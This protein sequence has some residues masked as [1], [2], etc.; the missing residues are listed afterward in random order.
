MAEMT[1]R[2]RMLRTLELQRADHLPCCFMSFTAL[3]KRHNENRYEQA[4]AELSMGL[5]AML[6][7][8]N[9]PRPERVDHPD[10]RGLPVR[11][12]PRV[13]VKEWRED[14]PGGYPVLHKEYTTPG[15]RLTAS[16]RTSADWPHGDHI[17]FID[18]YQV[19][20]AAKFLVTGPQDLDALRY[21][22]IPPCEDDIARFRQE[23]GQAKAFVEEHGVLLAGGWG[24]GMDMANWL[25]G[26]ENLMMWAIEQPDFVAELLEM[27]HAWNKKRMEVILS[28]PV[29]LFIRRAWYEGCD[30]VTPAFYR[31]AILPRLKAEVDLAHARGAKFG[32]IC[33]SGTKPMLDYYLEAGIDVLIG[34]DP[35]QGTH[36][37]LELIKRK[38]GGRICLWGGVSGAVTVE[39]GSEEEVRAAVRHAVRT[40]GPAGFILSPVDNITVDA[41]RTWENIGFFIDEWRKQRM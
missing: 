28:A 9:S 21:M 1:S 4:K 13:A 6:F 29:D 19:P 3:R 7:I 27:I 2:E 12:D 32:Y 17:P 39:M 8:P 26:M 34:I 24:V 35:I 25:C 5:D 40:L 15:G 10:L 33:S 37:D 14:G 23:A 41:P 20:R 16:V 38:L 18:D 31:E 22:L 11:F 30:F 36:T